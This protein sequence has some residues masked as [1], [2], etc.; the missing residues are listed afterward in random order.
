MRLLKTAA[1]GLAIMLPIAAMA[2]RQPGDNA[3]SAPPAASVAAPRWGDADKTNF[4]AMARPADLAGPAAGT[5]GN[6]RLEAA[7]VARLLDGK[8]IDL[9]RE[10]GSAGGTGNGGPQ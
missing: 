6:G 1:L 8:V 5:P 7:A 10:G 2:G 4:R 9:K 3:A